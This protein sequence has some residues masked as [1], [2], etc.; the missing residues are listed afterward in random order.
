MRPFL[1]LF[2]ALTF[3]SS[4]QKESDAVAPAVFQDQVLGQTWLES[5]EEE[6]PGSDVQV[7]RPDTYAFPDSRGR[8]GFRFDAEG[9]FTG[10]GPSPADGVAVYP[11]RWTTEDNHVFRITPTGRTS[12]YGLQIISLQDNVLRLRRLP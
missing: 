1:L 12:S 6:Q 11:G 9:G 8:M 2:L 5:T 3:F 4:C 10:Q 7:F